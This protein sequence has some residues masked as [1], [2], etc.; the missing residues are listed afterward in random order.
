MCFAQHSRTLARTT[1]P[2]AHTGTLALAHAPLTNRVL[3]R[4]T[5]AFNI[6]CGD[7]VQLLRQVCLASPAPC[8]LPV[9]Y[10]PPC[11]Y[12]YQYACVLAHMSFYVD[13]Y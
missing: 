10:P 2:S 5:Q 12:P 3:R 7:D 8:F 4:R 6:V 13:I 11:I 9:S 1:H